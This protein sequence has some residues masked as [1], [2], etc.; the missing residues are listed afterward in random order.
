MLFDLFPTIMT[1]RA[2]VNEANTSGFV[3]LSAVDGRYGADVT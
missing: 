1:T 2:R 3:E